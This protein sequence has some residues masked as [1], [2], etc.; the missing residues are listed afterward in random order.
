MS[1]KEL[2]LFVPHTF[3]IESVLS[4]LVNALA[5]NIDDI[6]SEMKGFPFSARRGMGRS[7]LRLEYYSNGQDMIAELSEWE[8]PSQKYKDML[9]GCTSYLV[10]YYREMSDARDAIFA[11]AN[12]LGHIASDC[13]FDNGNGCL[14][15]LSAVMTCL[16]SDITWSWERKVFPELPDV[17]T[18]EWYDEE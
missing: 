3:N 15:T 10:I 17:A 14:L 4:H 13:V 8:K 16:Q 7:A 12:T 5:L 6:P 9:L 18:S 11:I 2:M 1:A